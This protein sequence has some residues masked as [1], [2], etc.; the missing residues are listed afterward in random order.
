MFQIGTSTPRN[1]P[2]YQNILRSQPKIAVK[3]HFASDYYPPGK[4]TLNNISDPSSSIRIFLIRAA[5]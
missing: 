1:I 3:C 4:I 2:Y 5:R